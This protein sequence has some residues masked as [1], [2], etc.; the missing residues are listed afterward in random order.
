MGRPPLLVLGGF[1]SQALPAQEAEAFRRELEQRAAAVGVAAAVTFTGCLPAADVSAALQ[2]ADV[3]VL[4]FTHGV[5]TKSGALLT[6]L[7]HGLPTAV[8]AADEPDPE[9]RDGENVAVIPARRDTAAVTAT[10]LRLLDDAQLRH[11]LA[12]GGGLVA[13][14]HAWPR[15]AGAHRELYERLL[16]PRRG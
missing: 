7:A 10:L 11:R 3:A 6:V 8:T 4:P 5:T 14:R 2:A 13:A 12:E 9:L 15:I 16:E 1:T